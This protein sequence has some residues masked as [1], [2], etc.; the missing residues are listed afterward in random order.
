MSEKNE[1]FKPPARR[2]PAS[3]RV[4]GGTSK[5]ASVPPPPAELTREQVEAEQAPGPAVVETETQPA[6]AVAPREEQ[7]PAQAE[8]SPAMPHASATPPPQQAREVGNAALASNEQSVQVHA[9][10]PPAVQAT[11]AVTPQPTLEV[12]QSAPPS[13]PAPPAGPAQG[14]EV[15]VRQVVVPSGNGTAFPVRAGAPSPQYKQHVGSDA[16][17]NDGTPWTQGSGRPQDIPEAAVVLNQR[18]I[19]RESLD[20]SVPSALK[21]KKRIKRFALDNELDHL[22]ISDIV[23]VA[24]DEWLTTRGF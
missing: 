21:L 9:E 22:P 6:E 18:I 23:S 13:E 20:A 15:A 17:P 16:A 4:L 10:S 19:T 7:A 2:L 12:T 8:P 11:P 3:G 24:L 14:A 1:K 5:A